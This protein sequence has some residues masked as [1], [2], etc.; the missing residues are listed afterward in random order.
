MKAYASERA[1]TGA[2][3]ASNAY[4][5]IRFTNIPKS[6]LIYHLFIYS[7]FLCIFAHCHD[8]I[9]FS[10]VW[11]K[12][13]PKNKFVPFSDGSN[14][15]MNDAQFTSDNWKMTTFLDCSF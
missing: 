6:S 9:L 1:A 14:L 7:W 10:V 5:L 12:E 8:S 15:T 13:D 4:L 3:L 2:G 11:L